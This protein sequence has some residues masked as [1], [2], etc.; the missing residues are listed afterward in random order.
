MALIP[1]PT[2]TPAPE[3][4]S[5]TKGGKYEIDEL[6]RIFDKETGRQLNEQEAFGQLGLNTKF[7]PKKGSNPNYLS[8]ADDGDP[9]TKFNLAILDMLTKAQNSGGNIELFK[10]Q[11]ALQRA[12]IG[13]QEEVTPEDQRI[14]SPAQQAAIRSGKMQALE[15]EIDQVAASIKSQDSRLANFE[16]ILGD[17]REIGGELIKNIAPPKEVI[18]GYRFM[19]RA[20]ANPTSIPEEI[21]NKVMG[22]LTPEDWGAWKAADFKAKTAGLTDY[23]RVQTFNGIVNQYNKSPLIAASDRTPVL[24]DA[25]ESVR[26][27]PSNGALQLNLSYAYI[28]ALDTYQSAVREGELSN[29]NSIDSKVG[30]IQGY[31][32]KISNGQ[33]VRPEVA[34]KIADAAEQVINTIYSAADSKAKSFGAQAEVAGVG[35][36]WKQY[37][38]Q[39]QP[40]Y[41]QEETLIRGGAT[42]KKNSDGTYTRIK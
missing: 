36:E 13:R 30:E 12:A 42:F 39:F 27:N 33:I 4:L 14:L 15:P 31:A 28:Q 11:R 21:R 6:N 34:K 22:S 23:Q 8:E 10:Q 32:Q 7:L 19:I 40:S 37:I 25:I 17:V 9:M 2:Y 29:L 5:L 41:K 1:S 3:N 26:N 35:T 16:R 24:R 18:E 20:G 38:G